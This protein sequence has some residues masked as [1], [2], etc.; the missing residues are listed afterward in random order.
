MYFV[1]ELKEGKQQQTTSLFV[2]SFAAAEKVQLLPKRMPKRNRTLN[3]TMQ[4]ERGNRVFEEGEYSNDFRFDP[5]VYKRAVE[6][7]GSVVRLEDL[8]V[9]V[10]D[11][12]VAYEGQ[13]GAVL[14]ML[15]VVFIPL[16]PIRPNMLRQKFQRKSIS[17]SPGIFSKL[18]E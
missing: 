3:L 2:L 14:R 18:S 10:V 7:H 17:V 9:A 13:R 6:I 5:G 16:E 15:I 1:E 8:P 11:A 4:L 12:E